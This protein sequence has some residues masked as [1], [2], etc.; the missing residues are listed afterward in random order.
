MPEFFGPGLLVRVLQC[1][2]LVRFI[3]LEILKI[4]SSSDL[5]LKVSRLSDI[6]FHPNFI[7]G[8]N[9]PKLDRCILCFRRNPFSLRV[10]HY[11]DERS[12]MQTP[13]RLHLLK[14]A[15]FY[16]PLK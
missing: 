8:Y 3:G 14:G 12:Q 16:G 11:Y 2:N 13:R 15:N 9:Y 7:L 6:A 1:S 10:P 5:R 4:V